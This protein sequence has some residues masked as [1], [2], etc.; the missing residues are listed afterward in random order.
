MTDEQKQHVKDRKDFP[1]PKCK[2]WGIIFIKAGIPNI[3]ETCSNCKGT[4][5][6]KPCTD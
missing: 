4:G 2:G 5:V 6:K 3:V 1:C